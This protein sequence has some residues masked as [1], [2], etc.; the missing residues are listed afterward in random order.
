M[1]HY[2]TLTISHTNTLLH[3]HSPTLT[4]S[5]TLQTLAGNRKS[6]YQYMLSA[7]NRLWLA[8]GQCEHLKAGERDV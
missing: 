2:P 6:V 5:H 8:T 7:R 4:L 3:L 1:V